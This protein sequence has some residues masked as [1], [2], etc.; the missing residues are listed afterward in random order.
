MEQELPSIVLFLLNLRV[1]LVAP[2]FH[3]ANVQPLAD[4]NALEEAG[5]TVSSSPCVPRRPIPD[6]EGQ[7]TVLYL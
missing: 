7:L 4:C 2:M 6:M 3:A 1:G 5:Y